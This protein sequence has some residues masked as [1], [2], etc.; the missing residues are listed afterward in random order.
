MAKTRVISIQLFPTQIAADTAE[1]Q[2]FLVPGVKPGDF[3]SVNK[4]S[5][6]PGLEIGGSRASAPGQVGISLTN[7]TAAPLTPTQGEFW[8]VLAVS[9]YHC[10]DDDD[11]DCC[12]DDD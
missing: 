6:Q 3:V 5:F 8:T 9:P 4:P 10:C 1:E 7:E 11:D 12:D 2:L